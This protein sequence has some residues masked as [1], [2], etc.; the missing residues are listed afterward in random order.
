MRNFFGNKKAVIGVILVVV[1]IIFLISGFI[2]TEKEKDKEKAKEELRQQMEEEISN[3]EGEVSD[4]ILLNMQSDLIAAYGKLPEGYIWETDGSLLSLGDKSMSAEDV[5]YAYINGLRTLDLSM[6]QKYSR[7]SSVINTYEGYFND[8]DKNTDYT[9]H[10]IRNMYKQALLSIVVE[11]IEDVTTF[12][13]NKQVISVKVTMLD[14]TQ[15]DFWLNDKETI[16]K[17]LKL[18]GSDE[19]DSTKADMYLYEY[20]LDYYSSEEAVTREVTF[21]LTLQKYSDLDTGWLI[22]V[23]TDVDSA[24]RYLDG[25]LVVNYINEQYL[26]EGKDYLESIDSLE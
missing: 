14:L 4:N 9:D 2:N 25:K 22:S 24:C 13:E 26:E 23:D 6:V 17:N 5:V 16:Y 18:Y 11:K 8:Q 20:I 3:A 19:S 1:F 21:D 7:G 10:F 12:A 15:K